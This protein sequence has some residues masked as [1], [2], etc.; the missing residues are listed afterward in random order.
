M[1]KEWSTEN[2]RMVREAGR[3][4]ERRMEEWS[5]DDTRRGNVGE[6]I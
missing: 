1:I 6:M 5:E 3:G 2:K 4:D